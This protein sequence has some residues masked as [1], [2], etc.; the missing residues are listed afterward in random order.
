MSSTPFTPTKTA[1][2][3]LYQTVLQ[4]AAEGVKF[5]VH[6]GDVVVNE[7]NQCRMENFLTELEVENAIKAIIRDDNSSTGR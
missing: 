6:E 2:S 4:Q 3:A 5:P 1:C 7:L